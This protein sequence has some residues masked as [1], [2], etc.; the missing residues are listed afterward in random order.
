MGDTL[1]GD[2]APDPTKIC[3]ENFG[4]A[5]RAERDIAISIYRAFRARCCYRLTWMVRVVEGAMRTS[6]EVEHLRL[7]A[8][9]YITHANQQ[10]DERLAKEMRELAQQ[11]LDRVRAL[12]ENASASAA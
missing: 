10:V 9:H 12:E 8:L 3:G 5:A 6:I 7:Q 4:P 11:N 1:R 2:D